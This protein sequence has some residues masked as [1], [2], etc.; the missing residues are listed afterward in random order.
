M[1]RPHKYLDINNSILSIGAEILRLL[2]ENRIVRVS[3]IEKTIKDAK[4]EK[5]LVLVMPSLNLLYTLNK[6]EYHQKIDSIEFLQ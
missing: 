2:Q 6:I 4:G 3:D 5:A 1:I